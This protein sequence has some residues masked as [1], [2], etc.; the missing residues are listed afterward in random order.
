MLQIGFSVRA[1]LAAEQI[2]PLVGTV[3]EDSEI[4][5]NKSYKGY[6]ES[7]IVLTAE[8][9]VPMKLAIEIAWIQSG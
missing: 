6:K 9:A 8:R 7:S 3:P 5:T 4:K 1:S 2:L